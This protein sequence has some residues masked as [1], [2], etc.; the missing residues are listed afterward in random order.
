MPRRVTLRE[1][2]WFG[3]KMYPQIAFF[4]EKRYL[5]VNCNYR[6][7]RIWMASTSL[8]TSLFAH[9]FFRKINQGL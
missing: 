6:S 1:M 7:E 4:F 2:T 3:R 9:T 5:N 8:N